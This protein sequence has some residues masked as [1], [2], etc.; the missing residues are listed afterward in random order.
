[1]D[2]IMDIN[3]APKLFKGEG[4]NA[5]SFSSNKTMKMYAY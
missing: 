4:V 2:A 5:Y 1:M 3:E